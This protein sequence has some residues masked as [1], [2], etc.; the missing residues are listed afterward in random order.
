[1][2]AMLLSTA[3]ERL[4]TLRVELLAMKA[5]PLTLSVGRRVTKPHH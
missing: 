4:N 2:S 5:R 3:K 1:M